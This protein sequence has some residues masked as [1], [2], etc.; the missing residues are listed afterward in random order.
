[1]GGP[2]GFKK[3]VPDQVFPSAAPACACY[4]LRELDWLSQPATLR[5]IYEGI[6]W[7][8]AFPFNR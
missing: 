6:M 3:G 4:I 7:L 8:I 2:E 5:D 1:V